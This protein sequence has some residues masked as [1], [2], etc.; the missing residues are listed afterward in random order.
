[1]EFF[2]SEQHSTSI[3]EKIFVAAIVKSW[4]IILFMLTCYIGYD[5]GVKKRH[6]D[7]F[8]MRSR[9]ALLLKEKETLSLEKDDLKDRMNSQSDSYW[10]EQV[11]MKELGVVP[12]GQ[13][14]V[15]FKK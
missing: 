4:W 9:L 13:I 8:L 5:Q 1:M 6:R 2:K 14:K 10:I 11:L 7:I 3:V 12:E 15:H